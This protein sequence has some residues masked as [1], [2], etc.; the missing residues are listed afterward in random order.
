MIPAAVPRLRASCPRILR[1]LRHS[2]K[3][4]LVVAR[5]SAAFAPG[6]Q[7]PECRRARRKIWRRPRVARPLGHIGQ[8]VGGGRYLADNAL[9]RGKESP[10]PPSPFSRP[11]TP[12]RD[13]AE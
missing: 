11:A 7:R 1:W 9:L 13:P 8:L 2:P 3:K 10:G 6:P 12:R 5:A 4:Q